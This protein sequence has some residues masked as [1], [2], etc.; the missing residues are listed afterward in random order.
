MHVEPDLVPQVANCSVVGLI[1]NGEAGTGGSLAQQRCLGLGIVR[2]IDPEREV[3]HLLTPVPA[4]QLQQVRLTSMV[5]VH[6]TPPGQTLSSCLLSADLPIHLTCCDLGQC[7][8]PPALA[9]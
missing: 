3:V 9:D 2:S 6:V 7:Q 1:A 8:T 5:K 4:P